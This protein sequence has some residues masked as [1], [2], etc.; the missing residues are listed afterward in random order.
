[1][2]NP[3]RGH[4]QFVRLPETMWFVVSDFAMGKCQFSLFSHDSLHQYYHSIFQLPSGHTQCKTASTK[5]SIYPKLRRSG[6]DDRVPGGWD[7]TF[8]YNGLTGKYDHS[9]SFRLPQGLTS[10]VVTGRSWKARVVIIDIHGLSSSPRKLIISEWYN[11]H[12]IRGSNNSQS[13]HFLS[14]TASPHNLV[15]RVLN[16]LNL[17]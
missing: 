15:F 11:G 13:S 3:Y 14:S 17:Y 7:W 2:E 16:H 8:E 9:H 1:M 12:K 4:V 10:F 5:V 6:Y